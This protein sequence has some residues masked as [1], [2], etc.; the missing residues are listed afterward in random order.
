[1]RKLFERTPTWVF[2]LILISC[3]VAI[4][5]LDI[6]EITIEAVPEGSMPMSERDAREACKRVG[7]ENA[8]YYF[9]VDG[10]VVCT[11]KSGHVWKG[12]P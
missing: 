2:V 6:F 12:Q 3:V 10:S 7:G 11:T 8:G 9:K 1:M 4:K 5:A